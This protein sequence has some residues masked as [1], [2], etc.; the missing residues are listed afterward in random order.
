MDYINF[1][2]FYVLVWDCICNNEELIVNGFN[3][4]IFKSI[5]G[6]DSWSVFSGGFFI[7]EQGCIG[8]V[9]IQ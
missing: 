1:D 3:V 7:D 8:L 9:M 6:G 2:I 4:K 5:N